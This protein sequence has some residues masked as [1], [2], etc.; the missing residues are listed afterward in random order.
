MVRPRF[1]PLSVF[2]LCLAMLIGSVG[3][4]PAV[5]QDA[6]ELRVWD[7]FTDPEDSAAVDAIYT[8]FTD[9]NPNIKITREVFYY[10]G[11]R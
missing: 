11:D 4:Q 6:I 3:I 5:A 7:Q 1:R 2:V 10:D 8:S 9:A